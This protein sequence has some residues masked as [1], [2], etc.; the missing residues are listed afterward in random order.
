MKINRSVVFSR[1][2]YLLIAAVLFSC[3][4]MMAWSTFL[5][6]H[7]RDRT[8]TEEL[9]Q[10]A[11]AL[12]EKTAE[13]E[14]G[15]ITADSYNLF[16][17]SLPNL[18]HCAILFD[19]N[20]DVSWSQTRQPDDEPFS[21]EELEQAARWVQEY[22]GTI[23]RQDTV[24]LQTRLSSNGKSVSLVGVPILLKNRGVDP[25][26]YGGVY[27]IKQLQ[28]ADTETVPL[29]LSSIAA[30][31]LTLGMMSL[32]TYYVMRQM[33][34]PLL[35]I[36]DISRSLSEGDFSHQLNE[37]YRGE[38][39][40]L[41][42]SI[43]QMSAHLQSTISDLEAESTRLHQIL[44]GLNEGI[45][46][47]SVDCKLSLMNPTFRNTFPGCADFPPNTD[48]SAFPLPQLVQAVSEAMHSGVAQFFTLPH[49]EQTYIGQALRMQNTEGQIR[50]VVVL[51]RD[52]TEEARL[53]ATR[54]DYVANVSHELKTP[55]TAMR[56]ML[57]PLMDG[58]ITKP[59][60]CNRYYQILLDE[61]LRM[62]R[63]IDDML[64]LSRLQSGK[65]GIELEA[66]RVHTLLEN[67]YA[68]FS[69]IATEAGIHFAMELPEEELPL[70]YSSPD[71]TE[72]ILYIYL[73]NAR[74]F[75]PQGGEI[76]L[77]A[78]VR[79]DQICI[80]VQDTGQGIALEDQKHIFERFYKAD[81]S[82]GKS[83]TGLGLSI[84]KE[85]T[86]QT[87]EQV[88]VESTLGK[89]SR[90]YLSIARYDP[91]KHTTIMESTKEN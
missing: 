60:D 11:R 10:H 25:Q 12:S 36:R 32:P 76:I 57:E 7:F 28:D 74:K 56:C 77:R 43:N 53:E 48:L 24:L 78:E 90:F 68:K 79:E 75:T 67:L 59:E 13:Y 91:L 31:L 84:A 40:E 73:D 33:V 45:L 3:T 72:Q 39:G 86:E 6:G 54:R 20:K 58:L 69:S 65:T 16:I 35:R 71:R 66:F 89:G 9:T 47:F 18:L 41:S 61:T 85:I 22:Q 34:K 70:A 80:C 50:G 49:G 38:F 1:T 17:R 62:A 29:L 83:G 8:V 23:E 4:L 27:L 30:L 55:L 42:R 87:G 37:R 19:L 26:F 21:T 63:L 5:I 88:W 52:I 14:G 81:K 82:R 46:A 51:L 15:L 64:E 44:N 2:F